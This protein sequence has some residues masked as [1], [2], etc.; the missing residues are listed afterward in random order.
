MLWFRTPLGR[1]VPILI[2]LASCSSVAARC[3]DST[4]EFTNKMRVVPAPVDAA[5]FATNRVRRD[6]VYRVDF[7]NADQLL[8]RDQLL[9]ANAE[10]SII[11]LARSAGLEYSDRGWNYR[12]IACPSFTEHVFLQ[13]S[14]DNG[15]GD[16]SVFS[17][18]IP[19]NGMGKVR[20][21]PILKRSYSLFSPAPINAMTIS[22]FNH[23]RMEEGQSANEDWLG[24][25]LC[26]AALAGAQPQIL[27]TD[28]WP[29]LQDPVPPLTAALDVQF[30]VKGQEVISFDD[31][32][33]RPH[34]ME[35][36]MTF[37][38]E[39]KLIKATHKPSGMVV[40][41]P[42]PQKSPITG[43]RQIP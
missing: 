1:A 4:T 10:S 33:A 30:N 16:V 26:Y 7:K 5:P 36:S 6:P 41:K 37:T 8:P 21:V 2:A 18:S 35:W 23:I 17:A 43:S 19:R 14:R 38:R 25:A 40:A 11:E 39:G 9:V 34:A 20:I 29:S 24:N 22:A 12:E 15:S 28:S 3:Q 31:V 13:F 42:V 32:A 27:S